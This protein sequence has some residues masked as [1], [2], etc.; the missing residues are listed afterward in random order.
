ML[1]YYCTHKMMQL[2]LLFHL[3]ALY[4]VVVC[5]CLGMLVW[6]FLRGVGWC[7]G[8]RAWAAGASAG[9]SCGSRSSGM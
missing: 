2:Y 3:A 8:F 4:L 9:D 1:H 5:G 6:L 7:L